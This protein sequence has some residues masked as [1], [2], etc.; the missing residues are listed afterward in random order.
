MYDYSQYYT[1][2]LPVGVSGMDDTII[3]A[4]FGF[5]VSYSIVMLVLMVLYLVA[6]WRLFKKAG[7]PGWKCL[8]PIY[9]IVV[10]F[11]I[12]GLSPWLILGYLATIIPIIGALI[13]FGITIYLA[14][15]LAKAFGKSGAF[16]VGLILL[17]P[18]FIC[19]LGFGSSEYI[20][21]TITSNE[22]TQI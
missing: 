18:I 19:I 4:I 2:S 20:G 8:I 15:S 21:N 10:L 6:M 12:A 11:K 16:A 13:S 3:G 7:E 5:L 14:I 9:N 22:N 1:T 17:Q